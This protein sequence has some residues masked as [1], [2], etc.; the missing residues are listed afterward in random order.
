[1]LIYYKFNNELFNIKIHKYS[2]LYKLKYE[3]FKRVNDKNNVVILFNNKI[4]NYL[5]D[6]IYLNKLGIENG[7]ILKVQEKIKGGN[8]F[9]TILIILIV[10]FL[11]IFLPLLLASGFLPTIIYI[12]ELFILKIISCFM[13]FIF[14]KF[15]RI[16]DNKNTI[17]IIVKCFILFLKIFFLF[18]AVQDLFKLS[19]FSWCSVL[20]SGDGLFTVSDSYC[21][22]VSTITTIGTVTSFFYIIVY[23]LLRSPNLTFKSLDSFYSYVKKKKYGVFYSWVPQLSADIKETSYEN[24]FDW[25]GLIPIIGP[26]VLTFLQSYFTIL[27]GGMELVINYL[28]FVVS[29][30]CS[31]KLSMG[32]LINSA[33]S[34]VSKASDKTKSVSSSLKKIG[35]KTNGLNKLSSSLNDVSEKIGSVKKKLSGG[36]R[37][38][39]SDNPLVNAVNSMTMND[40][41]NFLKSINSDEEIET[42]FKCKL[43]DVDSGCCSDELLQSIHDQFSKYLTNPEAVQQMKTWGIEEIIKLIIYALN[44]NQVNKDMNNFYNSFGPYKLLDDNIKPVVATFWRYTMCNIFYVADFVKNT[45]FELGTPLDIT[46]TIKCGMFAGIVTLPVYIICL[47]IIIFVIFL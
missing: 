2:S 34:M 16:Y 13:V 18:Y 42:D 41:I 44:V 22:N 36:V 11:F 29:L 33:K 1:M 28:S 27:D 39:N 31:K 12:M 25:I 24:K 15:P 43:I 10:L 30:G 26:I 37:K 9:T 38:N 5:D 23:A 6:N 45:I 3:I 40:N 14:Q 17:T 20:K 47:I 21:E 4:L 19:Y 32:N 35:V 46:D 7:I 8:T